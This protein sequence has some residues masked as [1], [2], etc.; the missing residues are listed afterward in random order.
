MFGYPD[1]TLF[2][3]FDIL[4]ESP[5]FEELENWA[6]GHR[7][8]IERPKHQQQHKCTSTYE[9]ETQNLKQRSLKFLHLF[10][11]KIEK[12]TKIVIS[13]F[14]LF[15]FVQHSNLS[16]PTSKN[17]ILLSFLESTLKSVQGIVQLAGFIMH[18]GSKCIRK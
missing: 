2:L 12:T 18:L 1:E 16:E 17:K 8:L 13:K 9:K 11:F 10:T 3:V 15:F 5:N 14:L 6:P 4:F 7:L